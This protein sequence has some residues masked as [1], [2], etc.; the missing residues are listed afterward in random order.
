MLPRVEMKVGNK[1]TTETKR[2][3]MKSIHEP[4]FNSKK[5]PLAAEPVGF[6]LRWKSDI[7]QKVLPSSASSHPKDHLS[8]K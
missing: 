3:M 6:S 4:V 2:K 1:E 8:V 5:P 7:L